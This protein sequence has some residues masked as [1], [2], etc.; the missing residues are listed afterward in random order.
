VSDKKREIFSVSS[1]TALARKQTPEEREL[2]NKRA[3]LAELEAQLAQSELDL[4]TLKAELEAFE[5]RYLREVGV[6]YAELDEIEAQIAEVQ[7][8]LRPRNRQ[9]RE[10]AAKA[11]AQ[12]RESA[13]T[14]EAAQK[15]G[16]WKKF[17][18]PD[19][20][21]KLY[22][23]VAKSIH[24]DLATDE[25]ERLHRQKLMAEANQAYADGDEARLQAILREWE[26]SPESVKGE[27]TGAELIRVI[28]KIAQVEERLRVIEAEMKELQESDLYQL[29]TQVEEAEVEGRDLLAELAAQVRE[30]VAQAKKRLSAMTEKRAAT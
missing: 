27:G 11:R 29:K 24:P 28:R 7:A 18:A 21:K 25:V 15:T 5:A 13:E 6:L 20:L 23:E 19:N 16:E 1:S 30:R 17:T 10:Q 14:A 3:Q 8:R 12:A 4:A 26:T 9:A 2:E 22:R